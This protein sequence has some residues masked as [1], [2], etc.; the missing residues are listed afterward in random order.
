[1]I[2]AAWFGG[3]QWFHGQP[4]WAAAAR[5]SSSEV[6]PEKAQLGCLAVLIL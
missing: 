1:M 5:S 6:L 3:S 4:S 2:E